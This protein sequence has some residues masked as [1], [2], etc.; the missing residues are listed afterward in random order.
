MQR[1]R[2]LPY[3]KLTKIFEAAGCVYDRTTGDHLVYRFPGALRPVVIPKYHEV[4]VFVIKNNMKVVGLSREQYLKLES[5][6]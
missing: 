3:Q 6:T 5:E 4:P 2:P 1:I